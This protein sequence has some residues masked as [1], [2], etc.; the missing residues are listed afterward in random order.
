M[1]TCG[2][3]TCVHTLRVYVH[4]CNMLYVCTKLRRGLFARVIMDRWLIPLFH[5][6]LPLSVQ[7]ILLHSNKHCTSDSLNIA[8]HSLDMQNFGAKRVC[9][10]KS[11]TWQNNDDTLTLLQTGHT[12]EEQD[13]AIALLAKTVSPMLKL[14]SLLLAVHPSFLGQLRGSAACCRVSLARSRRRCTPPTS[15]LSRGH[16]LNLL[17][18]PIVSA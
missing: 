17:L 8:H 2:I 1:C 12:Y 9:Y 14:S 10:L 11:Q 18:E 4:E 3:C 6:P 15:K 5:Q 13:P 7:Q 16:L